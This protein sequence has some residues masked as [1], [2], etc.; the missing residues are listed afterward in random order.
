MEVHY[1]M[2]I[3]TAAE[4]R[5]RGGQGGRG[6]CGA[7]AASVQHKMMKRTVEVRICEINNIDKTCCT[8]NKFER[9]RL[10]SGMAW[11]EVHYNIPTVWA[12]FL[13]CV[14]KKCVL[15]TV[16]NIV[17]STLARRPESS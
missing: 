6:D 1:T 13:S 10:I 4:R 7:A 12:K 8:Y 5:G 9:E 14:Q 3:D 17:M 15:S 2:C 11:S 16:M